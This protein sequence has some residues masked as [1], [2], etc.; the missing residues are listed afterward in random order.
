MALCVP[1]AVEMLKSKVV[2]DVLESLE[3]LSMAKLFQLDGAGE[4]I[5]KSLPLVWS[6][7]EQLRNAVVSIYVRLYLTANGH[8]SSEQHSKLVVGN[9]LQI[10]SNATSGELASLEKLVG[11]LVV[12]GHI[13]PLAVK[14]LWKIFHSS[15]K[16][17][18]ESILA[19]Q[20]LSMAIPMEAS[21]SSVLSDVDCLM[22][23]GLAQSHGELWN[24]PHM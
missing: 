11:L 7:D 6:Q 13:P 16:G 24:L 21:T 8:T 14:E 19:C 22:S 2:S 12:G 20:L 9:L 23:G 5:S 18:K 10:I 3:F 1:I 17:K 4:A 15:G